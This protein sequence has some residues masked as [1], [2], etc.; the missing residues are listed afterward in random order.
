MEM[1][2]IQHLEK[3]REDFTESPFWNFI[4]LEMETLE[5]GHVMLRLPYQKA[6][7]NVRYTIH[8]GIYMSVMDT[9]LGVFCRSLGYDDVVTIQMNTQFLKS[10][11]EGDLYCTASLISQS[12]NT[13]LVESKLL[14]DDQE[15]VG[16][17]TATFKVVKH[18]E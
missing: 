4:G 1:T 3:V 13:V 9:T 11:I 15:L 7:D 17:S 18:A 6:F 5:E 12:R 16:Y 2:K 14:N 8:G 10:V